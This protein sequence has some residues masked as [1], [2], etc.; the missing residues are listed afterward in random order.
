M[1]FP[2]LVG[3][4]RAVFVKW[5]DSHTYGAGWTNAKDF[6]AVDMVCFSLGWLIATTPDWISVASHTNLDIDE[7]PNQV[8]GIMTIPRSSILLMKYLDSE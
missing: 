3:P 4:Y 5:R 6:E 1:T 2:E 7:E 8:A